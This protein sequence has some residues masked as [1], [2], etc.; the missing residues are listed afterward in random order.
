MT[1]GSTASCAASGVIEQMPETSAIKL[2]DLFDTKS[3]PLFQLPARGGRKE[4]NPVSM[5]GH[6]PTTS[7]SVE[8]NGPGGPQWSAP[9]PR[10]DLAVLEMS[11]VFNA[12]LTAMP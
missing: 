10:S 7:E 4:P 2:A 5:N 1:E 8:S 11:H 9:S 12:S 3:T 6:I